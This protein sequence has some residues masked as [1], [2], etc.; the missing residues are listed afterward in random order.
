MSMQSQ[1]LAPSRNP[2]RAAAA[3]GSVVPGKVPAP[4]GSVMGKAPSP[5]TNGQAPGS[6]VQ[7]FGA[8]KDTFSR[9]SGAS[10]PSSGT[11]SAKG[12]Q[13]GLI[14]GKI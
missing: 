9:T 11:A 7:G 4:S 6:K 13:G 5:G 10:G 2:S 14:P 1:N 12:F 8:G 3:S